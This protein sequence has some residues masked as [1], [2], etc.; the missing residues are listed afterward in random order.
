MSGTNEPRRGRPTL[1]V[2]TG[3]PGT[4]KS[5]V[6]EVVAGL[7]QASVLGH[8]WAI[9]ALRPYPDL[10][11]V[12][13]TMDPPGHR[14]VGWSIVIALA[15]EQL[16][17]GRSVVVD[18]VARGPEVARCRDAARDES[19]RML[20]VTT[21][22]SDPEVH[23]SRIEHRRRRIPDWYE[24]GWEQ[25][26]RSLAGWEPPEGADLCLDATDRWEDNVSR[27]RELLGAP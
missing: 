16:R 18:G 14:M 19:S 7:S 13:D 3:V 26:E 4:G 5:A 12:L 27:V 1:I 20:L 15:R 25:V 6:A 24:L 2:V 11:H 9:D 8:D 22:C 10:Q 21:R 17:S 23:R